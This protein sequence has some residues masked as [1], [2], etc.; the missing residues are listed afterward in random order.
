[1]SSAARDSTGITEPRSGRRFTEEEIRRIARHVALLKVATER[2]HAE[3]SQL[4]RLLTPQAYE[5]QFHPDVSTYLGAPLPTTADLGGTH[6]E[7][8]SPRRSLIAVAARQTADQWGALV[9]DLRNTAPGRLLVADLLRVQDRHL[10]T[11]RPSPSLM[12][13]E[14][15]QP[16]VRELLRQ[17]RVLRDLEREGQAATPDPPSA[18]HGRERTTT[19]SSGLPARLQRLDAEIDRL[20]EH[21]ADEAILR[22]ARILGKEPASGPAWDRWRR[23]YLE[24]RDFQGWKLRDPGTPRTADRLLEPQP[25]PSPPAPTLPGRL[26]LVL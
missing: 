13:D 6:V 10:S 23:D 11:Q 9:I 3:R 20:T 24:L 7:V 16:E 1:M 8:A 21:L 17:R 25:T 22:P 4:R 19:P 26:D 2:G 5:Q 18:D 14:Q 15:L 12:T